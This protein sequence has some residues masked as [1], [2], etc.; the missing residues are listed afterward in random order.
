MIFTT[1]VALPTHQA[2]AC[3]QAPR[4][5]RPTDRHCA[6]ALSVQDRRHARLVRLP[7]GRISSQRA[8]AASTD[9][10]A[11]TS[12]T[13]TQGVNQS[14][15]TTTVT[16]SDNPSSF[17]EIVTITATV[18][19]VSPGQGTPTGLV[20]FSNG[21]VPICVNVPAFGWCRHMLVRLRDRQL[22]DRRGIQGKRRIHSIDWAGDPGG[23][24][25]GDNLDRL[26]CADRGH[27]TGRHV[28]GIESA[29][30]LARIDHCSGISPARSLSTQ[31]TLKRRTGPP[32]LDCRRS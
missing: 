6:Q 23:P 1:T 21:I 30:Q 29:V 27:R 31:L 11:S 7:P 20:D 12:S 3:R 8:T 4:R 22:H 2:A 17:G 28:P 16:S 10:G 9:Y 24:E 18:A 19:A 14:S 5:S 13:L 26:Q 32:V 25:G 15:T